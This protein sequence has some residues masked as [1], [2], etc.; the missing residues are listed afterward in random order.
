MTDITPDEEDENERVY[1]PG[2]GCFILEDE[3]SP[4]DGICIYCIAE[5]EGW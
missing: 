5:R 2:C 3:I 4:I 1:C